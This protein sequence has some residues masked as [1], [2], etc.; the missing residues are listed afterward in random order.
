MPSS[1]IHLALAMHYPHLFC[2]QYLISNY[3]FLL[4]AYFEIRIEAKGFVSGDFL[5]PAAKIKLTHGRHK[6]LETVIELMNKIY[7]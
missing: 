4:I 7:N 2:S 5:Y 6:H 1:Q 3:V